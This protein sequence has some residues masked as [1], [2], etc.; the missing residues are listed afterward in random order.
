MAATESD[1]RDRSR[2]RQAAL[3]AKSFERCVEVV[4]L[5]AEMV[6]TAPL[7]ADHGIHRAVGRQRLDQLDHRPA[8][9][10]HKAHPD[11]L[12]RIG[13][14]FAHHLGANSG[15]MNSSSSARCS[16]EH[17]QCDGSA[18]SK[19]PSSSRSNSASTRNLAAQ[20]GIVAAWQ[21]LT[22]NG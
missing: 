13:K 15:R 7:A 5:V 8:R 9:L 6:D 14:H 18:S 12:D 2:Q 16:R 17:S 22:R 3:C 11:L 10:G 4:D 20:L 21:P 1:G 19:P